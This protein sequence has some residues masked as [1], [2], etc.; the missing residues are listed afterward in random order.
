MKEKFERH[1]RTSNRNA[2]NCETEKM[3]FPDLTPRELSFSVS[4][5][6]KGRKKKKSPKKSSHFQA[7]HDSASDSSDGAA[8]D[9]AVGQ[10]PYSP[11]G[12]RKRHDQSSR[13]ASTQPVSTER[14]H[15]QNKVRECPAEGCTW[16]TE[17]HGGQWRAFY[18]HVHHRHGDNVSDT[19]WNGEGRFRCKNCNKHYALNKQDSH[20]KKCPFRS[21]SMPAQP[22]HPSNSDT[23]SQKTT[24][25]RSTPPTGITTSPQ[26]VIISGDP[27]L[28]ANEQS[29]STMDIDVSLPA[30]SS[31]CAS[32]II[33]SKHIPNCCK[34]EWSRV[35]TSCLNAAMLDNTL[36]AWTR[37]AML[38]KCVLPAPTPGAVAGTKPLMRLSFVKA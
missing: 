14:S 2:Y 12:K 27:S 24:P 31:V 38:P 16:K 25:V 23:L 15:I 37:L 10:V 33:T 34:A 4:G 30:L 3:F 19:W 7:K 6:N 22:L 18:N 13:R 17:P 32:P 26:T 20:A 1:F 8:T 29:H 9:T 36:E 35:F 28:N 5:H 11:E 21:S